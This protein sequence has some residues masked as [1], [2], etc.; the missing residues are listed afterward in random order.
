LL[1]RG[2]GLQVATVGSNGQ[3]V[4]KTVMVGR[5][6]GSDLEIVGGLTASDKVIVSPPDSLTDGVNV[7]VAPPPKEEVAKS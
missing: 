3:V 2:D 6:Y 1:F 4:M 7:H 5:D